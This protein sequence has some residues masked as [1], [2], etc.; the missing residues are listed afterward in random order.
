MIASRAAFV[1]ASRIIGG[2]VAAGASTRSA[3]PAMF[4]Q[5][6][7]APAGLRCKM[8]PA[9]SATKISDELL[10]KIGG[11]S[12]QSLIDGLWVMGWPTSFIEGARY[13]SPAHGRHL[14]WPTNRGSPA[15][16]R[17]KDHVTAPGSFLTPR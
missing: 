16:S 1:G 10:E 12:T 15:L 4:A 11:L 7:A 14:P 5:N 9:A 3:R 13:P 17:L 6:A 8:G 2:R